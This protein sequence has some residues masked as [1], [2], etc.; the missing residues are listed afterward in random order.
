MKEAYFTE[1]NIREAGEKLLASLDRF[2]RRHP[3]KIK[4]DR[5]ALIVLDMQRFFLDESS[6]GFLPSAPAIV[7][8]IRSLVEKFS[9]LGRPVIFT[10]HENTNNDAGM[11]G[12]WWNSIIEA[13]SHFA[14]IIEEVLPDRGI[15]IKK[16]S[17]D[18]FYMTELDE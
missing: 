4:R 3:L 5:I 8:N 1:D 15:I 9:C 18:A 14:E 6:P 17:Y 7:G 13:G 16:T 12:K 2:R 10:K 11:L